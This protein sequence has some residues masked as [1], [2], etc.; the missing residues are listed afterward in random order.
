MID[1]NASTELLDA[2][3][4]LLKS[5][6]A[7]GESE[8]G[9]E[10]YD[11]VPHNTHTGSLPKSVM[12]RVMENPTDQYCEIGNFTLFMKDDGLL[13]I[14]VGMGPDDASESLPSFK[15]PLSAASFLLQAIEK[16]V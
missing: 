14:R 11:L 3:I 9:I 6:D 15:T 1:T 4:N 7:E 13:C 16:L 2:V 5:E 12:L 8:L 10:F